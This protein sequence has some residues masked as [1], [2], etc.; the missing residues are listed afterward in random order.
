MKTLLD[1]NVL[2]ALVDRAH[3][4]HRPASKWAAPADTQSLLTCPTVEN[5]MLRYLIRT[6]VPAGDAHSILESLRD[7]QR[8]SFV[9]ETTP[10]HR[11]SLTGVI[12]YRQI[13]DVYLCQT[14]RRSRAKLA[15]FDRGLGI[16]RPTDT[17][18]ISVR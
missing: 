3:E 15:T 6:D 13:T 7:D 14:A 8:F 4:H 16:L 17:L 18:V 11:E 5:A 9:A 1:A 10:M 12:G 2:I